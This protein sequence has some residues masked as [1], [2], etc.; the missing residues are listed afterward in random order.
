MTAIYNIRKIAIEYLAILQTGD[1]IIGDRSVPIFV[2]CP[3]MGVFK[4]RR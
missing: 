1:F 3:F 2:A 4:K